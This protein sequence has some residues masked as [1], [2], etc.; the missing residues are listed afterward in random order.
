[1]SRPKFVQIT[2]GPGTVWALDADGGVWLH[3]HE[4]GSDRCGWLPLRDEIP[5]PRDTR[6]QGQDLSATLRKG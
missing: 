6:G 1:M 2:A 4:L 3:G 5:E